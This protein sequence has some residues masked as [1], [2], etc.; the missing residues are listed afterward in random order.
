MHREEKPTIVGAKTCTICNKKI[1]TEW[2]LKSHMIVCS[3]QEKVC[4]KREKP[5]EPTVLDTKTD[6]IPN[7]SKDEVKKIQCPECRLNFSTEIEVSKHMKS[8]HLAQTRTCAECDMKFQSMSALKWMTVQRE[9]EIDQCIVR[10]DPNV[11]EKQYNCNLCDFKVP[12]EQDLL[13]HIHEDHDGKPGTPPNKKRKKEKE[14]NNSNI[15]DTDEPEDILEDIK[16]MSLNDKQQEEKKQYEKRSD[17]WDKKVKRKQ[18]RNDRE[19]LLYAE[20]RR[21]EEE[22]KRKK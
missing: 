3:R 21:K 12:C 8:E 5:S 2:N 19:A 17:D 13:K 10:K 4:N 16:K 11:G 7:S 1:L 6:P 22:N 18:K 9:H 14:L 15:M 20:H